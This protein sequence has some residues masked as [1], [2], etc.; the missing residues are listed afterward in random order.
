MKERS[1][2][3]LVDAKDDAGKTKSAELDRK[4][5][6]V[7]RAAALPDDGKVRLTHG[8]WPMFMFG[9]RSCVV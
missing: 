7:C 2:R 5:Q 9:M 1:K 3:R 6:P 8:V 4:A